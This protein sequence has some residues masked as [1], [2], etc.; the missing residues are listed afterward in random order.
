MA[1]YRRGAVTVRISEADMRRAMEQ[2][3][4][5]SAS[6]AAYFLVELVHKYIQQKKLI[7][8]GTLLRSISVQKG[9]RGSKIGAWYRVFTDAS[10]SPYAA[11]QHSGSG[12]ISPKNG[13]F[14]YLQRRHNDYAKGKSGSSLVWKA[15]GTVGYKAQPFMKVPAQALR[16][17]DFAYPVQRNPVTGKA[18]PKSKTVQAQAKHNIDRINNALKSAGM[19]GKG[20]GTG[21]TAGGRG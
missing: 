12:P 10:S 14:L 3:S 1:V 18:L 6:G 8:K 11:M 7:N 5:R 15:R 21:N 19:F 2:I 13:E 17:K 4:D 9:G 20:S 16:E